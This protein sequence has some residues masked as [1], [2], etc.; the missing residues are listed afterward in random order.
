MFM[1]YSKEKFGIGDKVSFNVSGTGIIGEGVVGG[2]AF[3]GIAPMW[4]VIITK[5][6]SEFMKQT[7]ETVMVIQELFIKKIET[8]EIAIKVYTSSPQVDGHGKHI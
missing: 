5:R 1:D 3:N 8:K 2:K 4:C 7:P 6:D